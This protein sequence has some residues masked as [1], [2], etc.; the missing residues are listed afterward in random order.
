MLETIFAW[1][2]TKHFRSTF[3]VIC[4][5]DWTSKNLQKVVSLFIVSIFQKLLFG[6]LKFL[7]KSWIFFALMFLSRYLYMWQ[8]FSKPISSRYCIH[9]YFINHNENNRPSLK[10]FP[11]ANAKVS[12]LE[13]LYCNFKGHWV[14]DENKTNVLCIFSTRYKYLFIQGFLNVREPHI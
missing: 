9:T 10:S 1:T 8:L 2:I 13:I 11:G 4:S 6:L 3:G 14:L 7:N 5:C 12:F